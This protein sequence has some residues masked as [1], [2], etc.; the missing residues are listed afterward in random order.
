VTRVLIVAGSPL[1]RASLQSMLNNG[2]AEVVG[3]VSDLDSASSQ[4][5]ELEPEIVLMEAPAGAEEEWLDGL[6]DTEIAQDYAVMILGEQEDA[7]WHARA[8]REGVRAVLP[9]DILPEQLRAALEAVAAGLVVVRPAELSTFFSASSNPSPQVEE[10]LEPLTPREQEVLQ[11]LS[12]GLANKEIA[13]KLQ[14]SDHT[15][16]FH[17]ASI[18]GKLGVSTR[19]EAVTAGIRRGLVML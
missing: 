8:F 13:A 14:I 9:N 11:M 10:L 1:L 5:A 15:V 18:L 6:A 2:R 19:T 4:L 3:S 16:K 12:S 7:A 17:V